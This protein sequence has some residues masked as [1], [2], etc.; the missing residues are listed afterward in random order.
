ALPISR[1][2]AAAS[3]PAPAAATTSPGRSGRATGR[4]ATVKGRCQPPFTFDD[5]GRK[6][7]KPEC[8]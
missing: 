3:A 7:Y 4:A 1:P 5:A 2:T 6:I 8:F